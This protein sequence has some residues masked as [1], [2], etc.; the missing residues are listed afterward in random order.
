MLMREH[1]SPQRSPYARP[2]YRAAS[3]PTSAL[4]RTRSLPAATGSPERPPQRRRRSCAARVTRA[5]VVRRCEDIV[6][7]VK[8]KTAVDMRTVRELCGWLECFN[9]ALLEIGS[10]SPATARAAHGA[11]AAQTPRE[12]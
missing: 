12:P 5:D 1:A 8:E 9:S 7:R 6:R 11:A 2:L 10:G 3:M 4:Y